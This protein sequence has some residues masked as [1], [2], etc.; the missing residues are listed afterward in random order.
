MVKAVKRS[1]KGQEKVKKRSRKG[2][3]S[4][5][6]GEKA[7]KGHEKWSK[8]SKGHEKVKKRSKKVVKAVKRSRKGQKMQKSDGCYWIIFEG[9]R[10]EGHENNGYRVAARLRKCGQLKGR[11]IDNVDAACGYF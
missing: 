11:M 10:N 1:R 9:S 4:G 6:N 7:R 5:R 3:K 8:R 2:K